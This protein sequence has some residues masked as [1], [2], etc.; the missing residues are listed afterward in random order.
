MLNRIEVNS[1]RTGEPGYAVASTS[2]MPAAE[3]YSAAAPADLVSIPSV[4]MGLEVFAATVS[5]VTKHA[6]SR[7]VRWRDAPSRS[8]RRQKEHTASPEYAQGTG[9]SS[10]HV[11]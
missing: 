4:V 11:L 10:G 6:T 7:K 2:Q 3:P 8:G 1:L 9:R 5:A